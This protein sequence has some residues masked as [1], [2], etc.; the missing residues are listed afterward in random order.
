[1]NER[2]IPGGA[3]L[4]KAKSARQKLDDGASN[5][6]DRVKNDPDFPDAVYLG[7]K[8]PRWIEAELDAYIA[9]KAAVPRNAARIGLSDE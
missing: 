3:K 5:F 2:V 4:L 7:P 1:M 9:K 6:W 8:A